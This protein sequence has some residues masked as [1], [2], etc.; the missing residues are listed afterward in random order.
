MVCTLAYCWTGTSSIVD[1]NTHE[2][3]LSI[4]SLI[5]ETAAKL[6]RDGHNVVLVSS[7]AVGVGLQRMDIEERPK[8][9]PR[10]QVLTAY[11]VQYVLF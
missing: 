3:I 9:L 8:N 1:E 11:L 6:H 10:V 7:G 4:L 2:P 5:V